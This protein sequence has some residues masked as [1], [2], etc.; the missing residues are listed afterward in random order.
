MPKG[1][2]HTQ[3]SMVRILRHMPV[4]FDARPR[5]R[6]AFSGTLSFVAGIWGVLLPHLYLGGEVSFMA[7]LDPGGMVPAA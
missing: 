6:C 1:V 7:G 5:S 2:M 3:R 4:H